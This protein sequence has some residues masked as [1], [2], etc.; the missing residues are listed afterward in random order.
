MNNSIQT[1]VTAAPMGH[2]AAASNV[3][4][5]LSAV[6]LLIIIGLCI[7]LMRKR[8]PKSKKQQLKDKVMK[9]GKIDF[10]NII[11][12]SFKAKTLCDQLKKVCHPDL[13]AKDE[14]KNREATEIFA[15][16]MKHKYNYAELCKLKERAI[17][18]LG[19]KI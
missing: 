8:T 18:Q 1:A 5:Y 14:A 17:Q 9:E 2:L 6:E 19:I 7:A 12:S 13:F 15:L 3:W 11:D 10:G 16:L 4:L